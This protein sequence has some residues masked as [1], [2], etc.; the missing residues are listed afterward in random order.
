M[1]AK[2]QP[3]ACAMRSPFG[4]KVSVLPNVWSFG[5]MGGRSEWRMKSVMRVVGPRRAASS[6]KVKFVL[7]MFMQTEYS[8]NSDRRKVAEMSMLRG[9]KKAAW[10]I[11]ADDGNCE[12]AKNS[13]VRG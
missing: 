13:S 12:M 3:A 5:S 11:S 9:M 2:W 1:C 7:E 6:G 4:V 10:W 8:K